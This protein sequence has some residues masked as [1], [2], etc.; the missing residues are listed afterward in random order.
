MYSLSKL[1][2]SILLALAVLVGLLVGI[3]LGKLT[4]PSMVPMPSI[5]PTRTAGEPTVDPGS[6]TV[7][8]PAYDTNVTIEG[9][10]DC[11]PHKDTSGVETMECFVG[12]RDDQD[13]YYG[14]AATNSSINDVNQFPIIGERIGVTGMFKRPDEGNKYD[15]VG[16]IYY[17]YFKPVPSPQPTLPPLPT[18]PP[19]GTVQTFTGMVKTGKEI[20]KTYCAEG[21]Y[22]EFDENP[23][24]MHTLQLRKKEADR[25]D[26][27]TD[28]SYVGH[29][30]RVTGVYPAQTFFCEALSCGC[31]DF[32]GVESIVI[33]ENRS[34][35][36]I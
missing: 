7:V 35:R 29:R 14:L 23:Y 6:S 12:L 27:F 33:E 24:G 26:L 20:G 15:I 10:L 22:L 8:I 16:V 34:P 32:I 17:D 1:H 11:L 5:F 4:V 9:T 18:M 25:Y 36:D 30:V 21:I 13:I 19:V 31:E 28:T 2:L 3:P